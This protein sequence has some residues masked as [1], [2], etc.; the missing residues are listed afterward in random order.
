MPS[1]AIIRV[2]RQL[3]NLTEGD[4]S[5]SPLVEELAGLLKLDQPKSRT[6]LQTKSQ[7]KSKT[8]IKNRSDKREEDYQGY[9]EERLEFLLKN[10]V[11]QVR[12]CE[13]CSMDVH[14]K[15]KRNGKRLRNQKYWMAV[16]RGCH[17]YI[18]AHPEWAYEE[19]Y[20]LRVNRVE[21]GLEIPN[22]Q[23]PD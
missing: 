14:H 11:C 2:V 10:P 23:T 8:K 19:G 1:Q 21:I 4:E 6:I 3:Q 22:D 13:N 17:T 12:D 20:L 18:G 16:C 15:K 7:L 9:R 5:L